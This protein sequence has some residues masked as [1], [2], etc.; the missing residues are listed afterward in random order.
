MDTQIV[1]IV[2]VCI[3]IFLAFMLKKNDTKENAIAKK[4]STESSTI[5]N[6]SSELESHSERDNQPQPLKDFERNSKGIESKLDRLYDVMNHIR[7][8]GLSIAGMFAITFII[9]QCTG[10]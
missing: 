8:I 2:V 10:G 3:G 7:W 5:A 1:G 6:N 4:E 9:P